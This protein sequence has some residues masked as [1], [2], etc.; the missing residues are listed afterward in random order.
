LAAV[1]YISGHGFGHT[2]RQIEILNALSSLDP[3][4][5]LVIRTSA[6][7]W[8]FERTARGRWTLVA[9][10]VD[11]GV[12]QH[13]SLT[14]DA[15]TTIERAAAFYRDMEV[16]AKEEAALL[17]RHDA[18]V[19]IADAPPLACAAAAIAGVPSAVCANFTWDWIYA[20]YATELQR[21]PGLLATIRDAYAHA[22]A[23]WRMPMHGGFET[24]D[25]I[26]DLPFVA[27]QPRQDLTREELRRALGLP[28]GRPLALI[29]FGG[30]G[31]QPLPLD[32][33][34]CGPEWGI[35]LIEG[36]LPPEGGSHDRSA[37][38]Q[39]CSIRLDESAIY[40]AGLRYE[41]VVR[42]VDVVI[43][44]PGYGIISDCVASGTAILYTSRGRFA[45]YDVLVREMPKY[46]RC[47][48]I[49]NDD[50]RSGRW[51]AP[52]EELLTLAPPPEQP[53]VD[54][55]RVVAGMIAGLA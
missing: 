29:S 26:V 47:R 14:L 22:G 31:V 12:V 15:E 10:D 4:L 28:T 55:A 11:T 2:I 54:G 40:S 39:A 19:V 21:A 17:R 24:V 45:E 53:R 52:L 35:V 20:G 8:L 25:P 32:R 13:D 34:D 9:G 3:N 23:G 5:P 48:F 43:T 30:Y 36:D 50:L 7:R 42:A 49:G 38:L 27:R 41:D 44:K 18:S 6:P 46:L 1:F 51:R 37:G 16:R 33:L